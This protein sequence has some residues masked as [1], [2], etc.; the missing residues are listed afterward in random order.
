MKAFV[1]KYSN[2]AKKP[3]TRDVAQGTA[4]GAAVTAQNELVV[5]GVATKGLGQ[6]E[7]PYL[8]T[9]NEPLTKVFVAKFAGE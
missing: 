2:T 3:W 9:L 6:P 1:R 5:S 4:T 8:E 7:E